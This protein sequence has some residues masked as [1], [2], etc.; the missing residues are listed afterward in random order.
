MGISHSKRH[1]GVIMAVPGELVQSGR[2][3][4]QPLRALAAVKQEILKESIDVNKPSAA[5]VEG[6]SP[7]DF[8]SSLGL[9]FPAHVTPP[10][11]S[12]NFQE[13]LLLQVRLPF[14]ELCLKRVWETLA[15]PWRR[16]CSC[17]ACVVKRFRTLGMVIAGGK[18]LLQ[19]F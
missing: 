17:I 13:C 2:F 6:I 10:H 3:T 5:H 4:H 19:T 12:S 16:A 7:Q 8:I 18:T 11:S 9:L 1:R 14:P 15:E